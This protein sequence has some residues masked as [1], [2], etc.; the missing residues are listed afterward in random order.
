MFFV[1]FAYL[2][3]LW[4]MLGTSMLE[5]KSPSRSNA[6]TRIKRML[7]EMRLVFHSIAALRRGQLIDSH[8]PNSKA[9]NALLST[10]VTSCSTLR[11]SVPISL[12]SLLSMV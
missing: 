6:T 5:V 3:H 2:K 7:P 11:T 1:F 10:C 12:L 4:P 8:A 9:R